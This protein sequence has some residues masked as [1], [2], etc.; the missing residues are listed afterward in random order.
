MQAKAGRNALC[1]CIAIETSDITRSLSTDILSGCLKY[2]KARIGQGSRLMLTPNVDRFL[3]N[4]L[5]SVWELE[6]LLLCRQQRER[7]W[8]ADELVHDLRASVLIVTDALDALQ[9]RG[10]VSK[11]ANEQY[12]YWPISPE[13]GKLVEDLAIDYANS[14]VA[15]TEAILSAPSSSVRIFADAFK[16]KKD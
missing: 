13:L 9:N 3:R 5:R 10:L 2:K 8:T 14:P 7:L 4:S 6:L 12:Q 15:V 16:I 1:H 11:N